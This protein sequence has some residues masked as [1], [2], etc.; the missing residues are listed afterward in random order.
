MILTADSGSTKCHWALVD[1][2]SASEESK[3]I[4]TRGIN[5]VTCSSEQV[6]EII[7]YLKMGNSLYSTKVV[8]YYS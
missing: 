3:I 7:L 2:E 5:P 8:I 6:K 4:E 1:G